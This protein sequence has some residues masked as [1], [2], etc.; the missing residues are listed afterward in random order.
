[1]FVV[2]LLPVFS[3]SWNSPSDITYD[4]PELRIEYDAPLTSSLFQSIEMP[5]LIINLEL[6]Y[7]IVE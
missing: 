3:C 6:Y 4:V 5:K 7:T 2:I 1:M